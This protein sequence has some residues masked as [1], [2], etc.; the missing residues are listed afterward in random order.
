MTKRE[1]S[2]ETLERLA[3]AVDSAARATDDPGGCPPELFERTF[4]ERCEALS[5]YRAEI[6]PLRTRAEVDADIS[7]EARRFFGDVLTDASIERH[8][9][10]KELVREPTQDSGPSS[11]DRAPSAMPAGADLSDPTP[12]QQAARDALDRMEAAEACSC[13]ESEALRAEIAVLRVKISDCAN[14]AQAGIG[15]G[16]YPSCT[17]EASCRWIYQRLTSP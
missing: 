9:R 4:R 3:E 6:A 12:L 1:A 8:D 10:L 2:R 16:K 5:A 7:R 17:A 14:Y 13:E 15:K 11:D